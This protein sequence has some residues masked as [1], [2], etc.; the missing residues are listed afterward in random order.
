MEALGTYPTY[1]SRRMRQNEAMRALVRETS[2]A[3]GDFIYP[4]FVKPGKGIKEAIDSMPGVYRYSIDMLAPEIDELK[5]LGIKC[6]LLFG[7]PEHKDALGS[8]GYND[9]GIV[10]QAVRFIKGYDKDMTI[11]TDV[12]LCEYTDHGHCGVLEE[13][14]Y[15]NNDKTLELLCAE[16]LSHARAGAHM[17]APS[18]MMDGH[19]Q[20]IRKALDD[21]GFV[22]VGIMAYSAKYSS[23][24][25]GPFRE[26]AD[27]APSFGDRRA[28]QMDPANQTEGVRAAAMDIAAG[29]DLVMVKPAM[30]YLDV[31][32][33]IHDELEF[34]CVAYNVSGEYSM[35]KAAA[36]NGWIDEKRVVLELLLSIKRAGACAI[37]TYHAKDAAR[38]LKD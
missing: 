1:R 6:V 5:S 32:R 18:D 9:E 27:S 34:P 8:E 16:A 37:I 33:R 24:F 30:A 23:G 35:V 12:C 31:L 36:A 19:T 17:V 20:A 29:A 28:Y 22:N 7:L 14:G 15:V 21:A 11:I 38:W 13:D 2:L 26:A 10:Q 25:Y 4:L 3:V